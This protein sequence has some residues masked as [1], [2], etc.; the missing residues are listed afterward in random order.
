MVLSQ[1]GTVTLVCE[2]CS[3]DEHAHVKIEGSRL[4]AAL[5]KYSKS[6]RELKSVS[7]TC[8]FHR[9]TFFLGFV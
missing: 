6:E 5:V 2:R 9:L 7:S 4:L 8:C 3:A 1:Q